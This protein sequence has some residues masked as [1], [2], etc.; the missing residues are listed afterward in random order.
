MEELTYTL[1][2]HP[3]IIELLSVLEQNNL[4]QQREEVRVLVGYIEGMEEK[5][6]Q[7]MGEIQDMHTEVNRLH[8]QTLR[9]K[10]SQL[11]GKAGDKI[12]QAKTMV[13]VTKGKLIDSAGNAVKTFKEKGRS[14]LVQAVEAMRIP[15]A[16]ARLKR[17]FSHT[18]EAMR[19][20]AGR[21]DTMREELHEVGGHM[22]NAGRALLGKPAKQTKQIASDKGILAKL[23]GLLESCGKAF[24]SMERGADSL[25]GKIQNGKAPVDKKQS[26][27]S[28]LRQL[29][30]GHTEQAKAPLPKEQAR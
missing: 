8:D 24:S 28:E 2:N 20:S 23:R 27:K 19:Q 29:K 1:G 16:L 15:A 18:A 21:L 22:K 14:A 9:A 30:T 25:M 26:V 5:L 17:G 7:M 6:G 4:Q 12:H 11:V 13:S 10:C 3:Q